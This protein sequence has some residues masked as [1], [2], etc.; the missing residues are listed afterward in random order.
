[1]ATMNYDCP[2][3]GGPLKFNP[4]K[5]KFSCE[6]CFSDF[7]PEA[8]QKLYAEKEGKSE[9]V[10]QEDK[11]ARENAKKGKADDGEAVIYT[12]PSC[13][14]EVIT[15]E[16][17]AATQCFYCQNPVVLGGRLSGDLK[18]DTVIPFVLNKDKAVEKFMEMCRKKHFLPKGFASKDRFD[19]VS[20]VYFP[21]WYVDQQKQAHMTA[22]CKKIR[23]WTSGNK[24]YEE[25]SIY[26]VTR[27]G[28]LIIDNVSEFAMSG[29]TEDMLKDVQK[30]K[31]NGKS[32]MKA[33][34]SAQ[35]RNMLN[36]VHPFDVKKRIPFAMSYL[37]GFQAEKRDL[38]RGDLQNA[39]DARMHKYAQQ[40]LEATMSEYDRISVNTFEEKTDL[41]S[42][43]YTLLPV[44]ITTYKFRDEILPFAINGQTGKTFGRLPLN[45][46]KLAMFSLIVAVLV[47]IIG[48]LGGTLFL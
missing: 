45:P 39:V 6:Y 14:A 47:F 18:P 40:L 10:E 43:Q 3:C 20:G 7:E 46:L 5:Q 4:D 17:T 25:T 16:S 2:N 19:K 38:D 21:Y 24:E 12:C 48:V 32:D 44:W 23:T 26:D 13:G 37:S 31:A 35:L 9:R 22:T 33:Q 8:I 34:Q 29:D 42:W 11:A 27:G 1:M 28:N 15:A 30:G 41:E 36:H